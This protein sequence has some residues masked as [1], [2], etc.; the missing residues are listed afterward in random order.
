METS[1]FD[2]LLDH[3]L[4]GEATAEELAELAALLRADPEKRRVLAMRS[5]L[6]V[7]M[8][9]ASEIGKL[10]RTVKEKMS[11]TVGGSPGL[12][13]PMNPRIQ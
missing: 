2:L 1:R 13:S 6:E 5:L 12:K 4:S 10:A 3:F 11:F 9:K 7:Q 8:R